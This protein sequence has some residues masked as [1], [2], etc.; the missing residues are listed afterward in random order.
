MTPTRLR[1]CLETLGWSQR[2]LARQLNRDEGSVRMW[3]RGVLPIPE[4][5]AAAL[6]KLAQFHE[7]NPLPRRR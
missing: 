1:E 3:A 4:D 2:G 7:C 5:V 6:E